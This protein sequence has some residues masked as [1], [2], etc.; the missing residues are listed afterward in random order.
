MQ[1]QVSI[2]CR[3]CDKVHLVVVPLSDYKKWEGGMLIQNAFPYLSPGT[4]ELLISEL[5]E[6]CFDKM[7][8]KKE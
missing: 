8:A 2:V 3:S 6:D 5:C 7:F 1:V 4:R